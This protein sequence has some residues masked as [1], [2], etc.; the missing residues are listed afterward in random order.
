[1]S[2]EYDFFGK[3]AT[4]DDKQAPV[5]EGLSEGYVDLFSRN[6]RLEIER[7]EL[8]EKLKTKENELQQLQKFI[9]AS[10][11]NLDPDRR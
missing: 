11:S 3:K 4:F 5:V 1:M 2:L 8:A 7:D 6:V 10:I 9:D